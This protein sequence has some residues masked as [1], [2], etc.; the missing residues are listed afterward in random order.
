MDRE[1][2]MDRDTLMEDAAEDLDYVKKGY[3]RRVQGPDGGNKKVIILCS[4]ILLV[5]IVILFFFF[6]KDGQVSP[7]EIAS[8]QSRLGRLETGA[9][10]TTDVKEKIA[11]LGTAQKQIR[12]SIDKLE[13]SIKASKQ[14]M[15][16]LR[17]GLEEMEKKTA[18]LS[19]KTV[20]PAPAQKETASSAEVRYYEVQ[21]KDTLY[22]IA[23]KHG[24]S[25]Q[26]LCRLNNINP[27]QAIH[28]GQKLR[29]PRATR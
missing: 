3:N 26:E 27:N 23:L 11:R 17:Q 14:Q 22:R 28:P 12:E 16:A 21:P 10:R 4:A 1:P 15:N 25:V 9:L 24:L 18:A 2:D 5:A 7:G 29:I 20:A 6:G 19:E 13:R 8:I